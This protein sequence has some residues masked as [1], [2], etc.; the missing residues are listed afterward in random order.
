L[1]RELDGEIGGTDGLQDVSIAAPLAILGEI[2]AG[3]A[4]EP[5][6]SPVNGQTP[7]SAEEPVARGARGHLLK[8][9]D[10]PAASAAVAVS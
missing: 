2:S 5:H 9:T 10:V 7:T 6:R 4:H 8:D 3:L 1:Q